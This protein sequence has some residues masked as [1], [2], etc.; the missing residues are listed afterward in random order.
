M[1]R[2]IKRVLKALWRATSPVR[3][4]LMARFD[5]RVSG[6]IAGTVNARMMP[7]LVEALAISGHRLER[8]EGALARADRSATAL[9]EEIDLVLNGL[10]REVFRMQVQLDSLR[11][12][13]ADGAREAGGLSIVEESG[14][15]TPVRRPSAHERSRVG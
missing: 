12:A 6:L 9:A 10:S 11:Q 13:V 3:R 1:K 5:A 15:E 14:E 8:I 7:T 2:F 4:P